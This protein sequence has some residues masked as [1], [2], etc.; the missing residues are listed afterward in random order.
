MSVIMISHFFMND[1]YPGTTL[2]FGSLN[3]S[4]TFDDTALSYQQETIPRTLFD[5]ISLNKLQIYLN[6]ILFSVKFVILC[7][8][9][10]LEILHR[11]ILVPVP[12]TF[13]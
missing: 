5:I 3:E 2:E 13:P 7:Y 12:L 6:S 9:P 4:R 10:C 8:V 1:I 11:M